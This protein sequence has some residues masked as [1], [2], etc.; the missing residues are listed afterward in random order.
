MQLA[1]LLL[2]FRFELPSALKPQNLFV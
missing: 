2:N 1:V